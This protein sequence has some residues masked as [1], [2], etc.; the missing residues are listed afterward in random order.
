MLHSDQNFPDTPELPGN[1]TGTHPAKSKENRRQR[2]GTALQDPSPLSRYHILQEEPSFI[3][4][5]LRSTGKGNPFP[6]LFVCPPTAD[7]S[8]AA[9]RGG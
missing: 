9:A 3:L 8:G 2:F 6:L 7:P 4:K 5:E 1:R